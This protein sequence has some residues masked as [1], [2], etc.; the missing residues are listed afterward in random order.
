MSSRSSLPGLK[1]GTRLAGT[2]T[3]APVFGLRPRRLS[4]RRILKLPKPR[5]SILSPRC[6]ASMI[7]VNT[8][9]TMTS[10]CLRVSSETC[11]TCSTSSAFVMP[12][13]RRC[14]FLGALARTGGA[15]R[16]AERRAVVAGLLAIALQLAL[17]LVLLHRAQRESDL[18]LGLVH[19]DD[20]ELEHVAGLEVLLGLIAL[21]VQLGDV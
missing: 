11:A 6:S 14:L 20:L 8:A 10:E 9:S 17:L 18:L 4:R 19:L 3:P 2:T 13:R 16:V 5:S 15:D 7:E 21:L 1:C 12:P